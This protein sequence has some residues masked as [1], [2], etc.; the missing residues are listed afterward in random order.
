MPFSAEIK[1][2]ELRARLEGREGIYV[3]KGAV[4]VRVS[5]IGWDAGKL[6]ITARLRR[7]RQLA[8]QSGCSMS[9][10][11]MSRNPLSWTIGAG[12]L[13]M[14]SKH[15][16]NMGNGGWCIFFSAEIVD[17]CRRACSRI[18]RG[19]SSLSRVPGGSK[20]LDDHNAHESAERVFC[21]RRNDPAQK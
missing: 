7:F 18:S 13:T 4:R 19:T 6:N 17:G 1:V 11:G 3:E 9:P 14:F 12:H 5:N 2:E 8:F 21:E 20:C 16:W 10:K 15:T